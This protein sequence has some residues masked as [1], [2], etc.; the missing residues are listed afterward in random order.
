MIPDVEVPEQEDDEIYGVPEAQT[1]NTVTN[2]EL[3]SAKEV[4]DHNVH[5]AVYRSWCP[6]C[7]AA[8]G[9]E[10]VHKDQSLKLQTQPC[11]L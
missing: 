7:V 2:T 11:P 10:N 3:P 5:H 4:E 6:V 1:P 9:C 8:A